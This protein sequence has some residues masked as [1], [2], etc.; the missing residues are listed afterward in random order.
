MSY[1]FVAR[2]EDYVKFIFYGTTSTRNTKSSS[3][4]V[5]K[6]STI[7]LMVNSQSS[8][9]PWFAVMLAVENSDVT[10]GAKDTGRTKPT[11]SLAGKIIPWSFPYSEI[12]MSSGFRYCTAPMSCKI[13]PLPLIITV[14][15]DSAAIF[16]KIIG[17]LSFFSTALSIADSCHVLTARTAPAIPANTSATSTER[18]E[19]N[20]N[21]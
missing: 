7:Q 18:K 14:G 4:V 13:E 8:P 6:G 1:R 2:Q 16:R 11:W 21:P 12:R 17:S 15:R 5:F 9:F 3:F 19:R 20:Q 10:S